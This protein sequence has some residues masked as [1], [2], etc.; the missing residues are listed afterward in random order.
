MV[1]L[2]SWVNSFSLK[3]KA[4]VVKLIIGVG[5]VKEGLTIIQNILLKSDIEKVDVAP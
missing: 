4:E 5:N 2:S 3:K 1:I